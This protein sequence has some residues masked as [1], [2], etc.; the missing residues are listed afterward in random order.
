MARVGPVVEDIKKEM[1]NTDTLSSLKKRDLLVCVI[2]NDRFVCCVRRAKKVGERSL[3][4]VSEVEE[5]KRRKYVAGQKGT[6]E[7]K[8]VRCG[9]EGKKY[10]VSEIKKAKKEVYCESEGEKMGEKEVCC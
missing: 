6:K 5:K 1:S 9:S 10:V 2:V 4:R 3:L 8:E 7:G